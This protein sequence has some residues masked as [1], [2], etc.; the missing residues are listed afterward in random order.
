[1][2]YFG[3]LAWLILGLSNSNHSDAS[4]KDADYRCPVI[5]PLS[6]YNYNGMTQEIDARCVTPDYTPSDGG[7]DFATTPPII[8][9]SDGDSE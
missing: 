3:F 5:D 2:R 1:M 8:P 9:L 4:E 6:P 7:E